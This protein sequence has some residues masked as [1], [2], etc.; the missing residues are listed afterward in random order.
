MNEP[1]VLRVTFSTSFEW[2]RALEQVGLY[3]ETA[4]DMARWAELP[5]QG[6][7]TC[8]EVPEDSRSECHAWSALPIYELACTIAGIRMN[9]RTI[10]IQPNLSYLPD[11]EGNIITP[12]GPVGFR[13]EKIGEKC[14]YTL[15]LPPHAPVALISRDGSKKQLPEDTSPHCQQVMADRILD[16]LEHI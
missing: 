6:N 2:F 13:Y 8:P 10:E 16:F 3:D 11:L 5:V 1:N 14:R 15:H 4:W 12:Y 7:T 9:G